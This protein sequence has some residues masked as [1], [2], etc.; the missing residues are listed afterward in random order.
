[1]PIFVSIGQV[2]PLGLNRPKTNDRGKDLPVETPY[3]QAFEKI[4]S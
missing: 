2:F 1:M 3:G 4:Q